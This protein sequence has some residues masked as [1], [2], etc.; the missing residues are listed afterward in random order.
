MPYKDPQDAL[1]RRRR[2]KDSLNAY[3]RARYHALKASEA[4]RRRVYQEQLKAKARSVLMNRC[5]RCGFNANPNILQLDH[6]I[7]IG[8]RRHTRRNNDQEWLRVSR[9]DSTNLQL[10]CPTCHAEKTLVELQRTR[11]N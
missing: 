4:P 5:V 3:N 2:L 7:P 1:A 11:R 9:G 6:I 10:L 8:G